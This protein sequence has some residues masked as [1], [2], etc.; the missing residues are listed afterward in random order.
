MH[1]P[2]AMG[3]PLLLLALLAAS[4]SPTPKPAPPAPEGSQPSP[5]ILFLV[6]NSAS[7]PPLDP[8]EKRVAALEKMFTFLQGQPYRLILFGGKR[9]IYVD[10]VARYNNRG[11][12]TDFYSAFE[13]SREIIQSYPQGTE[14]RMILLTDAI[15]DPDPSDW[16]D[17]GVPAGD[18]L[19]QHT[20]R[21]T[22]EL[23][24]QLEQPLYV[25]LVGALPVDPV[26]DDPEYATP[27]VLDMVRAA[28]GAL[29]TPRAQSLASFFEDD[30]LLLRKFVYRVSPGAGLARIEPIV[31]RIV[32]P[33]SVGPE[34]QFLTVLVLPLTLFLFVMLGLL[35]RSFPGP[36]DL[37]IVELS[38]GQ[39]IHLAAD[40]LHKVGEGGWGTTGLSQVGSPRE[41][42]VTLT[43]QAPPL[44]LT[45]NGLERTGLD[46]LTQR[47][48]PMGLD[49][50]RRA[51]DAYADSGT[52]EEKIYALNLDYVAKNF[53]PAEA[54]RVLSSTP[55]ER[56]RIPALDFLRAK[57][58]LLS[59]DALRRRLTDSRVQLVGYGKGG[60]RKDLTPGTMAR[61]GRYGF[62]VKDVLHGGRR[63]VRLVLYYDRVPSLLALKTIL[64]D[65][66]QRVFRMRRSSQRIVA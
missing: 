28:N 55:A 58:H 34:F 49:E 42:A 16:A 46:A 59:N 62:I 21:K 63:D 1:A 14:F 51:L 5:V 43:Y 17:S 2:K 6:D 40:R 56:R 33:P 47:L 37:E 30:G 26:P 8:E 35:V 60:E 27:F 18:P 54:E 4:A 64:P 24:A 57:A 7:L 3:T 41:A 50:L 36:G 20:M 38:R 61:I 45:G 11:Q 19:R 9:E 44:D 39:P 53:D 48:L 12:W 22:V 66:F 25:I 65:A 13:R 52:K 10:D 29:A 32:A 31:R 15:V 23:L